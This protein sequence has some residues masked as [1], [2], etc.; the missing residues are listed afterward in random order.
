MT[1]AR[2]ATGDA[3]RQLRELPDGYGDAAVVDY[4]WEFDYD[5]GTNRM[6]FERGEHARPEVDDPDPDERPMFAMEDDEAIPRLVDELSRV[7][8]DGSWVLFFADDRFQRVVRDALKAADGLTFRRN[9][10]WTPNRLGMGYYGR[11]SHYPIP[12][13]TVGDT[14]RY[15]QGRGTLYRVDGRAEIDYPTAKPVPLYR[16]LLAPPVLETGDRLLEPFCGSAPGAVVAGERDVAYWA[17]DVNPEAVD[18]A[19][20]RYEN[21]ARVPDDGQATL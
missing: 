2:F 20:R 18:L 17:C 16:D 3:F 10:A 14:E 21:G 1:D 13:A 15:V 11:V 6:G 8:A 7:L 19:E 4:P 5:N 12:T 9:W